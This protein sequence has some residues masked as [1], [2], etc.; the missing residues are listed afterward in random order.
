MARAAV[1]EKLTAHLPQ[2][3]LAE[4]DRRWAGLREAMGR[5]GLDCLLVWGTDRFYALGTANLRYLTHIAAKQGICCFPRRGDPVAFVENIHMYHP[6][7]PYLLSQDWVAEVRPL[8]GIDALAGVVR[9]LGQ[10]RGRLGI[11]G[12]GSALQQH[13]I[14]YQEYEA[15]REA[16]PGAELVDA[17]DVLDELRLIKSP[18]EIALLERSGRLAA[19]MVEALLAAARPGVRECEVYAEMVRAH[20]AAGGEPYIFCFFSADPVDT[21][22]RY[23]L[24][25]RPQPL[26][27]TTRPLRAGDLVLTEFHAS[28]GGYLTGVEF[29]AFVGP[30]PGELARV[31]AVAVESLQS[32]VERLR[33]GAPLR[34]VWEA[35]RRPV[36][37][38]GMDYIECGFHG[39]GLGSP[40]FP[41]VVYKPEEPVLSGRGLEAFTLRA[42]MVLALNID[43]NDPHWRK[44][45][46]IMLGD[47]VVVG[48]DGPRRLAEIP[49]HFPQLPAEG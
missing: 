41:T 18:E 12:Y 13:I 4:R 15:L 28:C 19:A 21:C 5:R 11:V 38:A 25:A 22:E 24:H 23:L 33:P 2:L 39:H 31:H 42:G 48:E 49:L 7:P 29:S 44:D 16:L 9:D 27:P 43:I 1:R 10:A 3:S 6:Y 40:E 14:A 26:A 32:G 36:Q 47:T 37:E 30:P 35:F 20:I 46:G 45:V 17:T 8:T 34:E